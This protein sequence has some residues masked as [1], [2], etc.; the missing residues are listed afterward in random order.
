VRAKPIGGLRMV[1]GNEADDKIIAVLEKDVAYGHIEE[2]A[3]V[4]RG[5]V[6]RLQ[7]YF[8]TY[9]QLPQESPRRVEIANVYDRAA[10]LET[11]RRSLEDYR[12]RYG[13]PESRVAELRRL[14][15]AKES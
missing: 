2:I 11:I 14:L 12:A 10:A 5:L 1:D 8:L 6:E 3:E 4:P 15:N 7:H 9:K 13:A